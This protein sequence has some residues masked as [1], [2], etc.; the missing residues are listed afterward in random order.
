MKTFG[1]HA[2]TDFTI[3]LTP[4]DPFILR[5]LGAQL[6][7]AGSA[8]AAEAVRREVAIGLGHIVALYDRSS[9]SYHNRYMIVGLQLYF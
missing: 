5:T 1:G 9:T 8:T 4:P 7:F 6:D 3:V 2:P